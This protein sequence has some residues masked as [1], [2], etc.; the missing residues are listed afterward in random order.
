MSPTDRCSEDDQLSVMSVLLQPVEVL[1]REV[2]HVEGHQHEAFVRGPTQLG[3]V[4]FAK[5]ASLRC[6]ERI[7]ASISER[8][9]D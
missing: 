3:L 2:A 7:A 6:G 1:G 8:R 5:T 9:R 4:R